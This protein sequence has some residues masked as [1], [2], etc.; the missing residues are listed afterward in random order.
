MTYQEWK[1]LSVFYS[2]ESTQKFLEKVY[3][4][5][6]I[7]D[8]KRHSFKNSE[9]FIFFLKHAESFYK[10]A[11]VSPLEIKPILLFYGMSQLLKA[12]LITTD[13]SYPSHTS[14]LA[15]GVTARKRKKQNYCFIEDEVK[16]QRNGLCMHVMKH[17]FEK[18]GIEDERYTMKKLLT[19]VPELSSIFYFQ[20]K[21]QFITRIEKRNEIVSVPESVVISYKMSDSRF[22]EYVSYHL[23]WEFLKKEQDNLLFHIPLKDKN[24]WTSTS[25]LFDIEKE[26]YY[27]PNQRDQFLHLPEMAIHYLVLYNIGMIARYETEWWYELLTQHAS[28][29]YVIIQHFIS[30]TESKFPQYACMFLHQFI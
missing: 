26:Q 14:V 28:D 20:Q 16:I 18:S 5:K 25:I 1:D 12:C 2:I 19:A 24:P 4:I 21:E 17:L 6:D 23:Q 22:A 30:I 11:S 10:Q 8:A 3:K 13:P 9:R 15:H 29:D 27:I 7:D